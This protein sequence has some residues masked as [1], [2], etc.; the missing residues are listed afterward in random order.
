MFARFLRPER[1]R[2][3][4]VDQDAVMARYAAGEISLGKA[5][6]SLGIHIMDAQALLAEYDL[7][8][9]ITPEDWEQELAAMRASGEIC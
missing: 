2:P 5:A 6:E 9:Q 3:A 7:Y 1:R 8:L 4:Q